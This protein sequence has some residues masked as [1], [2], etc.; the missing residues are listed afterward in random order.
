[1]SVYGYIILVI[2]L[3]HFSCLFLFR[4]EMGLGKTL[5]CI[6]LIWWVICV[7]G[8]VFFLYLCWNLDYIFWK[9]CYVFVVEQRWSYILL[10]QKLKLIVRFVIVLWLPV[11]SIIILE[12]GGLWTIATVW[13]CSSRL[14]DLA[15]RYYLRGRTFS[16]SVETRTLIHFS[17]TPWWE[18]FWLPGQLFWKHNEQGKLCLSMSWWQ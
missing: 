15:T 16:T 10:M 5:Q 14:V 8:Q 12:M 9:S 13:N 6:A 11:V 3:S 17:K 4:D 18:H 2:S 1:M 7:V